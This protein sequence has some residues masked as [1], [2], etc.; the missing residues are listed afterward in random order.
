MAKAILAGDILD[1]GSFTVNSGGY[2]A[3]GISGGIMGNIWGNLYI[4]NIAFYNSG[5]SAISSNGTLFTLDGIKSTAA[6]SAPVSSNDR[7][8]IFTIGINANS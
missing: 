8:N 5:R 7:S 6:V 1:D 4:C 2:P 3:T